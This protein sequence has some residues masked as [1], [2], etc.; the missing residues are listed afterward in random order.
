MIDIVPRPQNLIIGW[1]GI[2]AMLA[3]T[4][5]YKFDRGLFDEIEID[6]RGQL[7]FERGGTIWRGG[8]I[9]RVVDMWWKHDISFRKPPTLYIHLSR[10]PP[11]FLV[12]PMGYRR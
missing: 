5:V 3:K 11:E 4:V 9:W 2:A 7:F 10:I 1:L 12:Q 8:K 6:A